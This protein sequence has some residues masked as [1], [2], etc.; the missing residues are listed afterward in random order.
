MKR[1]SNCVLHETSR[2]RRSANRVGA[3]HGLVAG[4]RVAGCHAD[5]L[6]RA[7]RGTVGPCARSV[8][9]KKGSGVLVKRTRSLGRGILNH[10]RGGIWLTIQTMLCVARKRQPRILRRHGWRKKRSA[11]AHLE[12]HDSP[13]L[14]P[15]Y[16]IQHIRE[17]REGIRDIGW[18]QMACHA[19]PRLYGVI[20][21]HEIRAV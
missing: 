16:L 15:R 1:R 5:R 8:R 6:L 10:L 9:M 7:G 3:V 11:P 4:V 21:G 2:G 13:R 12:Q 14:Q 19:R 18:E 17:G 20:L